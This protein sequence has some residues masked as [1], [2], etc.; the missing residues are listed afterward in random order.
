[1]LQAPEIVFTVE[2]AGAFRCPKCTGFFCYRLP[3]LL[4]LELRQSG[5]FRGDELLPPEPK[6]P[7]AINEA[8]EGE[9]DME[10][11]KVLE[12]GAMAA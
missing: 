5:F 12:A 1:M 2:N 6:E 4:E 9:D 7:D 8:D 3:A 11:K 10:L